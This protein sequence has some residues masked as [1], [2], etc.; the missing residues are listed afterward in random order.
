MLVWRDEGGGMGAVLPLPTPTPSTNM[1]LLL[2]LAPPTVS[3]ITILAMLVCRLVL[4]HSLVAD[5]RDMCHVSQLS[6]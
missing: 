6:N 1:T 3:L 5:D 2:V 4:A